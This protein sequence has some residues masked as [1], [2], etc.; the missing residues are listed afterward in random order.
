MATRRSRWCPLR[1]DRATPGDGNGQALVNYVGPKKLK[2]GKRISYGIV[3]AS[4]CNA[5]VAT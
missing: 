3:C 1:V 5:T 2:I 4:N